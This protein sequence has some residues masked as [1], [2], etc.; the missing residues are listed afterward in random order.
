MTFVRIV[1]VDEIDS[2][3]ITQ[4]RTHILVNIPAEQRGVVL[5]EL[6]FGELFKQFDFAVGGGLEVIR[7]GFRQE[8]PTSFIRVVLVDEVDAVVITQL[9]AHILI[10]ILTKC[11]SVVQDP[12]SLGEFFK[13]CRLAVLRGLDVKGHRLRRLSDQIAGYRQ[14]DRCCRGRTAGSKRD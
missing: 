12:L 14:A 3:L 8:L 13:Q 7:L 11:R 1:L 5:D 9:G 6:P 10:D 2:L 4:I